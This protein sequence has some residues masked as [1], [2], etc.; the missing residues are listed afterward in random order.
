MS[1]LNKGGKIHLNKKFEMVSPENIDVTIS[2]KKMT[3]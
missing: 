1:I 2:E 3:I